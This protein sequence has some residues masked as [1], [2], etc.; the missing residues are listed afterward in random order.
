LGDSHEDI[1]R[2]ITL[3]GVIPNFEPVLLLSSIAAFIRPNDLLLLS[4]NLS[5]GNDYVAGVSAVLTQYDNDLT[6]EWLLTFL[7]DIGFERDDGELLFSIEKDTRQL[8]RITA[9][10]HLQRSRNI[11]VLGEPFCFSRGER[12]RLFFSYRHTPVTIRSLLTEHNI[13]VLDFWEND[14]G[15]EGVFLCRRLQ[16]SSH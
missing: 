6:R 2:V 14:R 1:V 8:C 16:R 9:H 11:R 13:S 7:L 10:F 5:P 15:D 4:A 12:I 3:F